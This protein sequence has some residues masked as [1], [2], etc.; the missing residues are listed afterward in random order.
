MSLLADLKM[1]GRF[2]WGLR[3][4]LRHRI[5]LHEAQAIVP[6]RMA[7]RENNFLR[8]V[9]RGV[10]GYPRSLIDPCSSS[11]GASW[12]TSARWYGPG[13]WKRRSR[14]YER[15]ESTSPLTSS[16]GA[17]PSCA[18]SRL[19]PCSPEILI[20]RI[21]ATTITPKVAGAPAQQPGWRSVC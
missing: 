21:S 8:L 9:E 13:G 18:A 2:A 1:Y 4:F 20:T 7:E 12:G 11:P 19:S 5:S 16:R 6:H 15:P 10:Y 14:P 3:G 17:C